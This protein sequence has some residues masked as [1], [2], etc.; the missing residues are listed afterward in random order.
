MKVLIRIILV[1]EL[2]AF[3]YPALSQDQGYMYGKVTTRDGNTY[4]GV[5]QWS[6]EEIYW[7]DFFNASK[8]DSKIF[9]HILEE[10]RDKDD[11]NW[12][13]IDWSLSG[14]WADK[15]SWTVHQFVCQFGNFRAIEY[16]RDK[17]LNITL[18]DGSV[19]EIGGSGYNDVFANIRVY[20]EEI[21]KVKIGSDRV[22]RIEFFQ[23]PRK[24]YDKPGK[25]IS[26]TVY[27]T[28]GE[29]FQGQIQWDHDECLTSEMLDGEADGSDMSIAFGKIKKI[30]PL[31]RGS[32]VELWSGRTFVLSGTNDVDSDNKGIYVTHPEFGRVDIPY[33]YVDLVE[34]DENGWSGPKYEEFEKPRYLKGKVKL[35]DGETVSGYIVYDMDE[36][37]DFETLEGDSH[38]VEYIVPF[39]SIKSIQPKNYNYSYVT[40]RNGEKVLLGDARDVSDKNG[41]LLVFNSQESEAVRIDWELIDRID[42]D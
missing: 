32:E 28:E 12:L 21:G 14:I 15:H 24:V 13:G 6:D 34:F 35:N 22:R 10:R 3:G 16:K 18:K 11:D 42:F 27:T 23:G 7:S 39:T 19:L 8:L 37:W 5:I 36:F 26:G 38:K 1:V 30:T 29:R 25:A 40:L 9:G 31:R 41:G 17:R 2:V 4:V 33:S 20:D